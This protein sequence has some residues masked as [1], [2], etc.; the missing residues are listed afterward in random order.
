MQILRALAQLG[1]DIVVLVSVR[2]YIIMYTIVVN[3]K[4][5]CCTQRIELNLQLGRGRES[6]VCMCFS[7]IN[8]F[9]GS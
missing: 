3:F 4:R 9:G 8:C 5:Y 6:Y 1:V 2:D 7:R